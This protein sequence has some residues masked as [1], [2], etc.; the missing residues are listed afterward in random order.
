[1]DFSF[2]VASRFHCSIISVFL[3]LGSVSFSHVYLIYPQVGVFA[4]L[5]MS[6]GAFAR[7]KKKPSSQLKDFSFLAQRQHRQKSGSPL[8]KHRISVAR[9]MANIESKETMPEPVSGQ[10]RQNA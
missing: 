4:I 5:H 9:K 10:Q 2:H 7:K 1:L 3:F 6:V 8:N